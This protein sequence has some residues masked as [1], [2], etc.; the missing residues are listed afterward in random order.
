MATETTKMIL[1]LL[2]SIPYGRVISYGKVAELAGCPRAGADARRV[3]RVLHSMSKKHALPWWRVVKK[4]G[5]IGL[6][7][8]GELQRR[9]LR[10]EGVEFLPSGEVDLGRFGIGPD[11]GGFGPAAELDDWADYL[12]VK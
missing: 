10:E 7:D 11:F 9:L 2:R 4:D 6:K 12:G 1:E 8:G 3:A 5:S